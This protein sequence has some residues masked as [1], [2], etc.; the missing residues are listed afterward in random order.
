LQLMARDDEG[1][2]AKADW[3]GPIEEAKKH[4]LT[5]EALREQLGRLGDT[6]FELADIEVRLPVNAMVPR[7]VLNNLRRQVI[8][9]IREQR[10]AAARVPIAEPAALESLR[11]G[12]VARSP[13]STPQSSVLTVLF[14]TLDQ[15]HGVLPPR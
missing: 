1:H 12:I 3:S 5:A 15:L 9:A 4:L 2:E 10:E 14:R 11:A 8:G 13:V 7:S 6:P